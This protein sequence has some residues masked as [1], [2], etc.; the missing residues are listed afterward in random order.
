MPELNTYPYPD[1][2]PAYPALMLPRIDLMSLHAS[3]CGGVEIGMRAELLVGLAEPDTTTA[4]LEALFGVAEVLEDTPPSAEL[5][6][7]TPR[8]ARSW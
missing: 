7:R 4:N 1:P 8:R 2:Q 5:Y 6:S 3:D